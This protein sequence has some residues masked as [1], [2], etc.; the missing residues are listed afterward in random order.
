MHVDGSRVAE[1][2]KNAFENTARFQTSLESDSRC[3]NYALQK[4]LP[5]TCSEM[6]VLI[7]LI[8]LIIYLFIKWKSRGRSK[9]LG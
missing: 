4:A 6:A 1:H 5:P 2:P 7:A 9:P 8:F 3:S